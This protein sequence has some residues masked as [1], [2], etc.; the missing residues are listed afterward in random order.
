LNLF[1]REGFAFAFGF[2]ERKKV[3]DLILRLTERFFGRW[4]LSSNIG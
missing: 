2:D 1:R 4:V 3:H